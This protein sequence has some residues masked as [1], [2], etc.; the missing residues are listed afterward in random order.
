M[1]EPPWGS[2]RLLLQRWICESF[3]SRASLHFNEANPMASVFREIF[4]FRFTSQCLLSSSLP[5]GK[6]AR[7][8]SS[9]LD[10]LPGRLVHR[11]LRVYARYQ[12]AKYTI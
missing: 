11:Q 4:F 1:V 9:L 10:L 8:Q 6:P 3:S 5:F 7:C 12:A 2:G